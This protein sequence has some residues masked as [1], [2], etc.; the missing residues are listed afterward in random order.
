MTWLTIESG[1]LAERDAVLSLKPEFYDGLRNLLRIGWRATDAHLLDL[2]RLRLAQM[3]STRAELAGADPD[4]LRELE[5]WRSSSAFDARER[6]ALDYAEQYHIHH[7]GLTDE[8]KAELGR[9]L[10]ERQ[11]YTFV[12]ALW[13]NDSYMRVLSLLD[14]EPDP[15]SQPFRPDRHPAPGSDE[16]PSPAEGLDDPDSLLDPEFAEQYW[17]LSR[18]IVRKSAVVVDEVTSEVVRLRNANHQACRF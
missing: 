6:A 13:A 11:I 14:V 17:A 10:T 3:M 8:Q 18:T 12:Y 1:A 16:L 9:H 2:C 4:L 7:S 5:D 15:P